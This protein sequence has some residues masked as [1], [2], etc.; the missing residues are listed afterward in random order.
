MML[1]IWLKIQI[2]PSRKI[3]KYFGGVWLNA[4]S[5]YHINIVYSWFLLKYDNVWKYLPYRPFSHISV[6]SKDLLFF[7]YIGQLILIKLWFYYLENNF[8]KK[9]YALISQ[10]LKNMVKPFMHYRLRFPFPHLLKDLKNCI[11]V[12]FL[13][14]LVFAWRQCAGPHKWWL[15]LFCGCEIVKR[16]FRRDGALKLISPV[17]T[18]YAE[19]QLL[20]NLFY[21]NQQHWGAKTPSPP[22]KIVLNILALAQLNLLA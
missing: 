7:T 6:K 8:P 4:Y 9:E 16:K 2:W 18:E 13:N 14:T 10:N 12:H 11:H 20:G 1:S 22:T 15:L 17:Y 21:L 19:K 5:S 3:L